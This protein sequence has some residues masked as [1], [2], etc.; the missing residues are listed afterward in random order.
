MIY[1]PETKLPFEN[2]V[3]L[4]TYFSTE[5]KCIAFLEEIKWVGGDPVCPHCKCK[6]TYPVKGR[7]QHKC[8][9]KECKKFFSIKT[10]TIFEKSPVPLVKWFSAIYLLMNHKKGISSHQL[11]KDIGVTQKTAWFMLHRVRE[12]FQEKYKELMS[13]TVE[14]DET[15]V[16]GKEKNK[17]LAKKSKKRGRSLLGGKIPLVGLMCR[18]KAQDGALWQKEIRCF[19]V[20]DV[21]AP[22]LTGLIKENVTEESTVMTDSYGGYNEVGLT[23]QHGIVDHSSRRYVRSCPLQDVENPQNDKAP[24]FIHTNTI[25]GFWGQVKRSIIGIYHKVS[26]KHIH[27][28]CYEWCFRY[29]TKSL[30]DGDRFKKFIRRVKCNRLTYKELIKKEEI[31][32]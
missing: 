27:R 8:G 4:I 6:N 12:M 18:E 5:E 30:K 11:S 25:E 21:K 22:T 10:G 13:G 24:A 32:A 9:N 14:V 29:N 1:N 26:R 20:S 7:K 16:G 31:K 28:Y 3:E 15:Y 17:H 2:L 23:Y 19:P